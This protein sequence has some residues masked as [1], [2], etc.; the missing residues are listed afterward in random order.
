MHRLLS[1]V[2]YEA[3]KFEVLL[4]LNDDAHGFVDFCKQNHYMLSQGKIEL[5]K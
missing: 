2:K 5:E 3:F 1:P 4:K